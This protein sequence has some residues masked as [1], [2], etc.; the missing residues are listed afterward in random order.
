MEFLVGSFLQKLVNFG[1]LVC[2]GSG[3]GCVYIFVYIYTVTIDLQ[4]LSPT[5][6]PNKNSNTSML[7]VGFLCM[8]SSTVKSICALACVCSSY[9]C[10]CC[11]CCHLLSASWSLVTIALSCRVDHCHASSPG[12]CKTKCL[13]FRRTTP[14]TT[15]LTGPDAEVWPDSF[16]LSRAQL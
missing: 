6:V 5:N 16:D 7:I 2:D 1:L 12:N 14:S 8:M 10:C 13:M 15:T 11:C 4:K 3:F 9:C